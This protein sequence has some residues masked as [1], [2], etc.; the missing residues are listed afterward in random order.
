MFG[1]GVNR[2]RK[3]VGNGGVF[4]GVVVGGVGVL[5][6]LWGVEWRS[7]SGVGG[8]KKKWNWDRY[9]TKVTY[10]GGGVAERGWGSWN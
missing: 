5:G 3:G 10:Q 6:G 9:Y 4:G 1:C 2:V 7:L 8:K